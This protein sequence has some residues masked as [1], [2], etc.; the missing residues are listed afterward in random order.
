M[1]WV[2]KC[3]L[4]HLCHI[5]W[6][7]RQKENSGVSSFYATSAVVSVYTVPHPTDVFLGHHV[8]RRVSFKF[9]KTGSTQCFVTKHGSVGWRFMIFCRKRLSWNVV[10]VITSYNF[11]IFAFYHARFSHSLLKQLCRC[12]HL[13][14]MVWMRSSI[15]CALRPRG[16]KH[17]KDNIVLCRCGAAAFWALT[18]INTTYTK[19]QLRISCSSTS[20][21]NQAWAVTNNQPHA[22]FHTAACLHTS[23]C[24][25][26]WWHKFR[27]SSWQEFLSWLQEQNWR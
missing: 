9:S 18:S 1:V 3:S 27:F 12:S 20:R 6:K 16:S 15:S 10:F 23:V 25:S 2:S 13:T 4:F 19:I 24:G 26:K 11:R 17:L 22:L 5:L 21:L 14:F 7:K 8:R